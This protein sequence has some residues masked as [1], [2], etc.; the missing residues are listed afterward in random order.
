MLFRDLRSRWLRTLTTPRKVRPIRR[1]PLRLEQLDDRVVPAITFD[2]ISNFTFPG[3]K[4][5]FV[6]L[7][8]SDGSE[9]ITYTAQSLNSSVTANVVTGGTTIK[10]TVTGKDSGGNTFTGD[11]EIRLF[12][13]IAPV[14]A[15]RITS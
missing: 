4:D 2:P 12:N 5:L 9:A 7:T 14:A 10:L 15:A 13:D 3:G 11:I 8:A 6:P 1:T